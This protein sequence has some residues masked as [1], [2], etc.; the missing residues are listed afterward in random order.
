MVGGVAPVRRAGPG[1]LRA[2]P[3]AFTADGPAAGVSLAWAP[4]GF[5][6]LYDDPAVQRARQIVLEDLPPDA[7]SCLGRDASQ[8]GG[9]LTAR[10]GADAV[11]LLGGDPFARLLPAELLAVDRGVIAG[12]LP[13]ASVV[14]ERYGGEQWPVDRFP[15]SPRKEPAGAEG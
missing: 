14:I 5:R 3:R 11:R 15:S 9:A 12:R 2:D 7:V 1:A 10:R 13:V 8:L 4:E 6:L